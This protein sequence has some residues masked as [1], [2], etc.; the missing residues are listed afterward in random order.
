MGDMDMVRLR[1]PWHLGFK[2]GI[3]DLVGT[4]K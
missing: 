2:N 3:L 4:V 1:L